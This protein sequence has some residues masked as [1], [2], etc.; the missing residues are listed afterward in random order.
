MGSITWI[1]NDA[2]VIAMTR[3]S[4]LIRG[5]RKD[6]DVDFNAPFGWNRCPK[7]IWVCDSSQFFL[8]YIY[9]VIVWEITK[10]IGD[11]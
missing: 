7:Q 11:V 8:G 10:T 4:L 6:K 2:R 9:F 5:Y 3:A 1:N